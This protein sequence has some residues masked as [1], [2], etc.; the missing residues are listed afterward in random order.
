M[1]EE[2][3]QLL[4]ILVFHLFVMRLCSIIS[5]MEKGKQG[6]KETKRKKKNKRER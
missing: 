2:F 4:A 6:G 5:Y 3:P 1:T